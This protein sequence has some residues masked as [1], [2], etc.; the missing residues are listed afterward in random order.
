MRVVVETLQKDVDVK[1]KEVMASSASNAAAIRDLRHM[2]RT[3]MGRSM[4]AKG[5]TGEVDATLSTHTIAKEA[6]VTIFSDWD[7]PSVTVTRPASPRWKVRD[8]TSSPE[9]M[10]S[11]LP[12]QATDPYNTEATA[13]LVPETQVHKADAQI[14]EEDEHDEAATTVEQEEAPLVHSE[15]AH[16]HVVEVDERMEKA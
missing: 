12:S 6:D 7:V 8:Q 1:F 16:D 13:E 11:T 3:F 9:H 2:F 4:M 5:I 14:M 15:R 10:H